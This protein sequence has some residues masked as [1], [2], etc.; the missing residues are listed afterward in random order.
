MSRPGLHI[1]ARSLLS[2][3]ILVML[4]GIAFLILVFRK[5]QITLEKANEIYSILLTSGLND[6]LCR[7]ALAQAAHETGGFT[8][9]IFKANNNAF[10]MKYAGQVNAQTEKNGYAYYVTL[11]HSV[12]DF[13]AWYTRHRAASLFSLPLF[14]TTLPNYVKFLKNNNYFEA[15]ESEY[16]NGC[17]F[18]YNQ[19][20]G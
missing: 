1:S 18:F 12:A 9:H 8:S 13:V 6:T 20:F 14:I 16:L 10:G 15:K 2:V 3:P 4:S 17:Q 7:F 19:I 5:K 11:N